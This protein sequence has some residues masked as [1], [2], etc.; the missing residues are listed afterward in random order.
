MI[1]IRPEHIITGELVSGAPLTYDVV[2]DLVEPMGSDTLVYAQLGAHNLR[3]RMDGQ[4][5]VEIG[6]TLAIGIDPS[7]ASLF[8]KISE[9]RL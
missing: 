5:R 9:D 7:R 8:D 2:V 3:I 6:Q 1:G 4:S